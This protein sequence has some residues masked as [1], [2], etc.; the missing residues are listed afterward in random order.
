ML[1]SERPR[2]ENGVMECCCS[3]CCNHGASGD[4]YT[5]LGINESNDVCAANELVRKRAPAGVNYC[6]EFLGSVHCLAGR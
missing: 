3:I 5:T 2:L 4:A 6:G 1:E